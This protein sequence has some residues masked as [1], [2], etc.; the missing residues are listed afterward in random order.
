MRDKL[1][2]WTWLHRMMAEHDVETAVHT[3]LSAITHWHREIR[4]VEQQR[5][6]IALAS[7]SSRQSR[8]S[9]QSQGSSCSDCSPPART[10]CNG[11]CCAL[12][13]PFFRALSASRPCSFD[14]LPSPE[15]AL[16][17]TP[18][19]PNHPLL[20]I[21]C[22]QSDDVSRRQ[23]AELE[24]L[25][26]ALADQ[27]QRTARAS[28][29][30]APRDAERGDELSGGARVTASSLPVPMSVVCSASFERLLGY[31]QSE[32]R[33]WFA[34]D[35]EAALLQLI[36]ADGWA[37]WLE[38]DFSARWEGKSEYSLYAQC[39]RK[40]STSVSCLLHTANTFDGDGSLCE[41]HMTF[42]R[43]P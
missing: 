35:G 10:L 18:D 23:N 40:W 8:Q 26:L 31:S 4:G 13:C 21:R 24:Q 41:R 38:L 6:F 12:F 30:V 28:A 39:A 43:L 22:L 11:S 27:L 32:L 34:R 20:V 29:S 5:S 14:W 33:R 2:H 3:A 36:R 42:I 16:T 17:D 9:R 15:L 1:V 19:S 37:R 25:G 7:A